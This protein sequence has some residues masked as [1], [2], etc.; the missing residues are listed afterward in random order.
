MPRS[1]GAFAGK[2]ALM[3]AILIAFSVVSIGVYRGDSYAYATYDK[4]ARIRSIEEPQIIVVGDSNVA[5][6]VSAARIEQALGMPTTNYGLHAGLGQIYPA[7]SIKALIGPGDIIVI[8]PCEYERD[9]CNLV[10][11]W[12]ATTDIPRALTDF[13]NPRYYERLHAFPSYLQVTLAALLQGRGILPEKEKIPGFT[14]V[15]SRR[16]FDARGDMAYPRPQTML[17]P[18]SMPPAALQTYPGEELMDYWNQFAAFARGKGAQV[19]MS[20]PP[21][22][23][24]AIGIDLAK[25]QQMLEEGLDFPVISRFEDYLFSPEYFYDTALHLTDAGTVLRTDRLIADL[26]AAM[27]R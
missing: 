24:R 5:L 2:C 16:S 10:L 17:T 4:Q 27:G 14:Q 23:D 8:A 21:I 1:K 19:Y 15:F 3:L 26:R 12:T 6:G 22:L 9:F 18:E 7:E 20:C 25:A 11:E 13:G